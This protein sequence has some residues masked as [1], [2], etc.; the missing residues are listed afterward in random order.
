MNE[1]NLK[2]SKSCFV[3]DRAER[4][5]T[6]PDLW[7]ERLHVSSLDTNSSPWAEGT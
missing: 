3:R 5:V 1:R 7:R 2:G 6:V 4:K